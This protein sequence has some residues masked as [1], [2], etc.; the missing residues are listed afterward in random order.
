MQLVAAEVVQL[1]MQ[2]AA[3]L[4]QQVWPQLGGDM[5]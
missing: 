2:L 3:L 5:S 1:R 4:L